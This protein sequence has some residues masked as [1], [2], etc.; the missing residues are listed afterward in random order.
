MTLFFF[1]LLLISNSSAIAGQLCFKRAMGHPALVPWHR[2][3]WIGAGL[4]G[5][6]IGFFFWLALLPHFPLSKIFPIEAIDRPMM[7]VAASVFL[8]EKLTTRL[9]LGIGVITVGAVLVSGT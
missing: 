9:I 5:G 2:P 3:A 4:V 6:A 7:A 8:R 1:L